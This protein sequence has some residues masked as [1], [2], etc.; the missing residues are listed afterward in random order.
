MTRLS[1]TTLMLFS[2]FAVDKVLGIL[3][4][5][6]I[7]RQFGLSPELDAFNAANNLPDL[8]FALISG[9]ALA[10]AFIPVLTETLTNKGR[11]P[12]WDLF[13][14]IA[15]LAFIVT[16]LLAILIAVF[17]EPLVNWKMGIAPGFGP[18][19]RQLVAQLMR[20][21]LIATVI[22]SISG[23]V[24]CGLQANQHFLLPAVA[25]LLYNVGQIFGVI[26][27]SPEKGY[28]I[29][30]F[31]LPAFN[32]GVNGLVYGVILGAALHLLI[33]IPGLVKYQF[34][35]IPRIGIRTAEVRQ[36]LRLLGPRLL[37][38]LFIQLIFIVRDNLASHQTAGA[39][40][41]LTYGWMIMQVPET[42]IGTALGTALLPTLAEHAAR[43]QWADFRASVERAVQ[44]LLALTIPAALI[45]CAGLKPLISLAF[46]FDL[47][48][49]NLIMLTTQ[50]YL[51]GLAAHSIIEVGSRAFYA[52]KEAVIPLLAS[53]VTVVVFIICGNLFAQPY[54]APGIALANTISFTVEALLLFFLLASK[55]SIKIE[56]KG[57]IIRALLSAVVGF[58]LVWLALQY[59]PFKPWLL[60]IVAMALAVAAALPFI[61][62]EARMIIRL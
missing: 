20:L 12:A 38:M 60:S 10:V 28:H 7:A 19:Q 16:G 44:V 23:L 48:G 18:Q 4:Q 33:Q 40:S 42:L 31:V 3:R 39:V 27:L 35:W 15:N 46:G 51:L 56:I 22:F 43:G 41:A 49:T 26:I 1:K 53:G 36:V 54:S 52:Q 9:G 5:I 6:L 59:I 13:S 24:M 2:L 14:R 21:N 58:G 34:H 30:S 17:A 57:T 29:G 45:L 47:S 61:W 8:L 37:T 62:K 11:N 50:A 32:L 25:P 55:K